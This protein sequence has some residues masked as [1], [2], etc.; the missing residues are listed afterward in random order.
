MRVLKEPTLWAT[1]TDENIKL[2]VQNE[3][4]QLPNSIIADITPFLESPIAPDPNNTTNI[5]EQILTLQILK[6]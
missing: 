6:S 2:I 3:T 5:Q 1:L 4:L